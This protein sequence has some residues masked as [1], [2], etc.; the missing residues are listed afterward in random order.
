MQFRQILDSTWKPEFYWG[1]MSTGLVGLDKLSANCAE[2]SL[3]VIFYFSEEGNT[4]GQGLIGGKINHLYSIDK[5]LEP[6]GVKVP[7][8]GWNNLEIKK[9]C[10]I[11]KHI[12]KNADFYFVHS[13][14]LKNADEDIVA[15]T[16][17]YGVPI[18]CAVQNGRVCATQFH[19]EKSSEVGLALLKNFV[20]RED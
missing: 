15:G 20:N 17:E 6:K 8:M 1:D 2:G 19:P 5:S 7:H 18:Q 9:E 13:Y 4:K 10:P 12:P 16:T 3:V 14:Y 11:L